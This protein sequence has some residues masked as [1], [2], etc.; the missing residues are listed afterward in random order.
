MSL[1]VVIDLSHHNGNV[2]FQQIKA[3][4]SGILGIIHKVTQ[5]SQYVDPTYQ[6]R[7]PIA[8]GAGLLWG[9]YHFGVGGDGSEQ[10]DH[11]LSTVNPDATDL[12]VLDLEANTAGDSMTIPQ[13]EDFVHHIHAVAGRWPGLYAGH[14]LRQNLDE[15]YSGILLNCWLWWAQYGPPAPRI[16]PAWQTWTMWQYTDGMVGNGQTSV[17]GAGHCDR[18]QFNGDAD[19][20]KR[21]WGVG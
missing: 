7:R 5:G 4:P 20:L 9:A 6:T 13:A 16:H 19:G 18:D 2:D 3:D 14:Y 12:L 1:N 21:L 10:A 15:D 11:F 8:L 17:L